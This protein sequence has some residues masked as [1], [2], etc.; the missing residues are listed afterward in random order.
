[1]IKRVSTHQRQCGCQAEDDVFTKFSPFKIAQKKADG[2]RKCPE[3]GFSQLNKGYF[4]FLISSLSII[5]FHSNAPRESKGQIVSAAG[6]NQ[7]KFQS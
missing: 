3:L 5:F 4:L 7:R 1:V 6:N 2:E